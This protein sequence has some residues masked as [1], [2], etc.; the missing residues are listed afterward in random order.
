MNCRWLAQLSCF[1]HL[2]TRN[3][4]SHGFVVDLRTGLREAD[5]AI[6]W[7]VLMPNFNGFEKQIARW[8]S[9]VW[10]RCLTNGTKK[11]QSKYCPNIEKNVYNT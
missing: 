4:G 1:H 3:G 11:I 7:N 10:K 5:G 2:V 6:N 8:T 9:E